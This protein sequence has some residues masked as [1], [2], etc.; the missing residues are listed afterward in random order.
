M[1]FKTYKRYTRDYSRDVFEE[2][3]YYSYL[4]EAK[5]FIKFVTENDLS[6][7]KSN[8]AM[9]QHLD[10]NHELIL[11]YL[12]ITAYSKSSSTWRKLRRSL[13][14]AFKASKLS[15]HAKNMKNVKNPAPIKSRAKNTNTK[16][17]MQKMDENT[18]HTVLRDRI[19]KKD[20][21]ASSLIIICK[22][23][24]IRP[25]EAKGIKILKIN[26]ESIIVYIQGAKKTL[27]GKRNE[28]NKRG[29]DRLLKINYNKSLEYALL[30]IQGIDDKR[31]KAAQMR[32]SRTSRRLY[33]NAKKHFC[34]YSLRYQYGSDLKKS[35]TVKTPESRKKIAAILGHKNTSSISSYGDAVSGNNS[36]TPPSIHIKCLAEVNDNYEKNKQNI[37]ELNFNLKTNNE[38]INKGSIDGPNIG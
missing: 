24:G 31:I 27:A 38:N 8:K 18:Y 32:I 26:A 3:T 23:L 29:I 30:S 22:N 2:K 5:A 11:N 37:E 15:E 7:I 12:K 28:K 19:N 21:D 4:N 10:E 1:L 36:F 9:K 16:R 25:S 34:L 35:L 13:E 33:P 6:D 17:R 14:V 20:I